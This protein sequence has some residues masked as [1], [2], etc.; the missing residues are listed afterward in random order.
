MGVYSTIVPVKVVV[1]EIMARTMES[2]AKEVSKL[3]Q[4]TPKRINKL[5]KKLEKLEDEDLIEATKESIKKTTESYKSKVEDLK[6]TA[7]SMKESITNT[8]NS[9]LSVADMYQTE[10]AGY[11][12]QLTE[13][14][15]SLTTT[16]PP[17]IVSVFANPLTITAGFPVLQAFKSD[18]I[19]TVQLAKT[20][21]VSFSQMKE[22]LDVVISQL[23]MA[24]TTGEHITELIQKELDVQ[25][26][27][28]NTAT[29]FID[30]LSGV[31]S[32]LDKDTQ[33]AK[34]TAEKEEDTEND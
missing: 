20:L 26:K 9:A 10:V 13:K 19:D 2:S 14:E 5:L 16:Y 18:V 3:K 8:L 17:M 25:E 23:K 30:T 28:I 21:R 31:V 34:E 22:K 27:L 1:A 6:N 7:S 12:S 33:E 11:L 24:K 32:K 15:L 29:F 4:D